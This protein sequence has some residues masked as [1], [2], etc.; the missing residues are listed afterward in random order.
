MFYTSVH[1]SKAA[2][3]YPTPVNWRND[4]KT[5]SPEPTQL[6]KAGEMTQRH[7]PL[8]RP[9]FPQRLLGLPS[10]AASPPP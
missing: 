7:P 5:P 9:S 4:K 1:H 2:K 8:N 10:L 6:S 3:S